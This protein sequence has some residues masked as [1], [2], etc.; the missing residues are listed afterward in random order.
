MDQDKKARIETAI[1]SY[2]KQLLKSAFGT[3]PSKLYDIPT[4]R[5]IADEIERIVDEPG[6][7]FFLW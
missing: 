5:N 4:P 6:D 1:H 2:T 3:P 7:Q